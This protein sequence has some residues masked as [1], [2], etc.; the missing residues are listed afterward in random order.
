MYAYKEGY[1]NKFSPEMETAANSL[2]VVTGIP[3]SGKDYLL[4]KWQEQHP[5]T[6]KKVRL[7]S[8]GET[9]MRYIKTATE[10]ISVGN[11]DDLRKSLTQAQVK[12][13]ADQVVELIIKQQPAIANTH[14]AYHQQGSIIINP[15][16]FKKLAATAFI[17]NWAD[18]KQIQVWR[19]TDQTRQRDRESI[20]DIAFFQDIAFESTLRLAKY[21]GASFRSLNNR[22]DNTLDNIAILSEKVENILKN[23]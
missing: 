2:L 12:M 4:A 13:I 1:V 10:K 6:A 9:M 16:T 23:K 17:Y 18:P 15:E 7:I 11:R 5:L 22:E 20:S 21:L 8:F 14:V 3:G 19:S